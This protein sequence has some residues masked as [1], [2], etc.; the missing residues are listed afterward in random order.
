MPRDFDAEKKFE[1]SKEYY[2]QEE[3]DSVNNEREDFNDYL[4]RSL[5]WLTFA[6]PKLVSGFDHLSPSD[7]PIMAAKHRGISLALE[8]IVGW[9]IPFSQFK[10]INQHEDEFTVQL[11]FS[12]FHF[13]SKSFFGSTWMGAQ[14][15]LSDSK[16]MLPVVI[17]V[18]YNELI[19]L[20]SRLTDPSCVGIAEIVVSKIKRD[21]NVISA[22]Y[23][24][25]FSNSC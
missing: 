19:Y 22:Q 24:F 25:A 10:N 1:E 23:G 2:R 7:V 12:L 20:I 15:S 17:D 11:S 5:K 18:E 16:D 21:K 8:K 14:V 6:K 3:K 9:V 4:R 13:N